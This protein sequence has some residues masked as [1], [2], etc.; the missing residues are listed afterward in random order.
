MDKLKLAVVVVLFV[1]AGMTGARVHAETPTISFAPPI[2]LIHVD[3]VIPV[4]INVDSGGVVMNAIEATI[5]FPAANVRVDHIEREQTAFAL[6]PEPPRWDN[7]AGTVHLIAGR[8]GG[9]VAVGARVATIYFRAQKP[10]PITLGIT[11]TASALYLNDGVGTKKQVD[12]LPST[13]TIHDELTT[14]IPLHSLSHPDEA[15][16][17]RQSNVE[18]QWDIQPDTVYSYQF[19][20]DAQVAPD[21]TPETV[22][23]TVS[24]SDVA[25]GRYIFSI[26]SKSGSGPWSEVSQRRFLIDTTAPQAPQLVSPDPQ[27]VNGRR[28]LVWSDVD[29]TS[30]IAHTLGRVGGK[31]I[32]EVQS[33]LSLLSAWRGKTIVITII[34]QAGN[35]SSGQWRYGEAVGFSSVLSVYLIV[36]LVTLFLVG[37]YIMHKRKK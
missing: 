29:A 24:Y 12:V 11:T 31:N 26:R 37:W 7:V 35:Q 27:T 36:F 4:D 30:G 9:M 33:P 8:P 10:G 20:A 23:G 2:G 16:W 17:Y 1:I 14:G 25:D 34:D 13:F 5:T 28:V 32:G 21:T 6:W 3:D 18:V 15:T 22:V 19:S